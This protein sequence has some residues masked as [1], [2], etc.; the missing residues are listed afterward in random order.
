MDGKETGVRYWQCDIKDLVQQYQLKFPNGVKRSYIY[1]HIPKNFRSNSM[2]AGLCNL[3]DDFGHSNFDLLLSLLD[4]LKNQGVLDTSHP[5]LVKDSRD[6]Q[7]FLKMKFGKQV[8]Y[9][10]SSLHTC[11]M[12]WFYFISGLNFMIV[13]FMNDNKFETEENQF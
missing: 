6:Y 1:A 7:K 5:Q 11:S 4:D 9:D 3:C 12:L 10:S 2:L 13:L 8:H